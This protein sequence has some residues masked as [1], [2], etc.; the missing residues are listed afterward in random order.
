MEAHCYSPP[1]IEV[2]LPLSTNIY[3][4]IVDPI[5]YK[6]LSRKYRMT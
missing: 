6:C 4:N 3:E 2:Q 5:T 1:K